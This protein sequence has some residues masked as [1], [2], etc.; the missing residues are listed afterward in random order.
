MLEK[1]S[2]RVISEVSVPEDSV[3]VVRHSTKGASVSGADRHRSNRA[4]YPRR[5]SCNSHNDVRCRDERHH[6][7]SLGDRWTREDGRV[8][9][10]WRR[11][12][13]PSHGAEHWVGNRPTSRGVT[14]LVLHSTNGEWLNRSGSVW[15]SRNGPGR[16]WKVL[17]RSRETSSIYGKEGR[18]NLPSKASLRSTIGTWPAHSA[19]RI[20]ETDP[21]SDVQSIH[22]E[23][24]DLRRD[25]SLWSAWSLP[26]WPANLS[27]PRFVQ[28]PE[29][30]D[31]WRIRYWRRFVPAY[32]IDLIGKKVCTKLKDI[33]IT[34]AEIIRGT[35][36]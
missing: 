17:R 31:S 6:R 4:M 12:S 9:V 16:E 22:R 27:H 20:P 1:G 21:S 3:A 11:A 36:Q 23:S 7:I 8:A 2:I 26:R 35:H 34:D 13:L 18:T 25:R 32:R 33:C 5:S 28:S 30:W 15:G 10:R 24:G 29:Q 14:C 19:W